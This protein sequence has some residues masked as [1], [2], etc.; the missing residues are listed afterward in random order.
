MI[1][2]KRHLDNVILLKARRAIHYR[3]EVKG[4]GIKVPELE[5]GKSKIHI[6]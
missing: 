6:R 4:Y 5:L 1:G 2:N 3:L